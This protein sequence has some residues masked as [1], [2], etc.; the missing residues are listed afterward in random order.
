[1]PPPPEA[2]SAPK[3]P[4]AVPANEEKPLRLPVMSGLIALIAIEMS[5]AVVCEKLMKSDEKVTALG[6]CELTYDATDPPRHRSST[7]APTSRARA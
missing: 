4:L 3:L 2:R 1:M 5:R 7:V 6:G